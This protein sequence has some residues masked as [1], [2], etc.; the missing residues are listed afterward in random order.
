MTISIPPQLR[1]DAFRFVKIIAGDK[2]PME[3]HWTTT[4]NY[5]YSNAALLTHIL[6]DNP[7]GVLCGKDT[8][9]LV[10]DFDDEKAFPIMDKLKKTFTVKT[11]K[12]FHKY[13]KCPEFFNTTNITEKRNI[14]G[15]DTEVTLVDFRHTGSQV[16][17]PGSMHPSGSKYEIVDDSEIAD[18]T[19]QE[20]L[21]AFTDFHQLN[22]K[23]EDWIAR[24]TLEMEKEIQNVTSSESNIKLDIM[25]LID[26]SKFKKIANGELRGPHPTHGSSGGANFHIDPIKNLW[27]CFRCQS[28][29]SALSLVAIIEGKMQCADSVKGKLNGDLFK[30]VLQ[31]AQEK[32]GAKVDNL[33]PVFMLEFE[34][35]DKN[36]YRVSLKNSDS[37]ILMQ[38]VSKDFY[39]SSYQAARFFNALKRSLDGA[40]DLK[41][42]QRPSFD[43]VA[44]L[45]A[46]T[47][48]LESSRKNYTGA[49][50]E[51]TTSM[52][53]TDFIGKV[54]KKSLSVSSAGKA[55][56]ASTTV[57][58][59]NS[60]IEDMDF[61]I[62]NRVDRLHPA[63][64]LLD[65]QTRSSPL[66]LKSDTD[67]TMI[68]KRPLIEDGKPLLLCD[69]IASNSDKTDPKKFR[70]VINAI[71]FNMGIDQ[72]VNV[73]NLVY[74]FGVVLTNNEKDEA[75]N[76]IPTQ[77]FYVVTSDREIFE[78]TPTLG[79]ETA[80]W[81]KTDKP[82]IDTDVF[83]RWEAITVFQ[84]LKNMEGRMNPQNVFSEVRDKFDTFINFP[85]DRW[86]DVLSLWTIGTYLFPMFLAYPYVFLFGSKDAGKT[87]TMQVARNMCF[88][89]ALSAS[90]TGA[91]L[92][93]SCEAYKRSLFIDEAILFRK[94]SLD[95]I[96]PKAEEVFS[97]INSGYK[98]GT[99]VERINKDKDFK[100][101]KFDVYSPKMFA[102]NEVMNEIMQSRFIEI[103][104]RPAL[105][106]DLQGDREV[107][108]HYYFWQRIRN[109]LYILALQHFKEIYKI[110]LTLEND[111]DMKN[112]NWELWKPLLAIAK[113]ISEDLFKKVLEFAIEQTKT[114]IGEETDNPD[115]IVIEAIIRLYT[116][117][118]Y[119]GTGHWGETFFY[120]HDVV[121]EC[122]Q[123]YEEKYSGTDT[124]YKNTSWLNSQW[125]GARI[126]K[127]AIPKITTRTNNR[128]KHMFTRDAVVTAAERF[129]ISQE[130]VE[131]I[132]LNVRS[133]LKEKKA[134]LDMKNVIQ[135]KI[136]VIEEESKEEKERRQQS[137]KDIQERMRDEN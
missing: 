20:V 114:R 119:L 14:N 74:Y 110:Y 48:R 134:E 133:A 136:P 103:T 46:I 94:Q 53:L 117:A 32:Y 85:D 18:I 92:F 39:M 47:A 79:L 124:Q 118:E 35:A 115:F 17:G 60:R 58:T 70:E 45:K 76:V 41:G 64:G 105:K 108:D 93:R 7:Y 120:P 83:C 13:F 87:K 97:L 88:N 71:E 75:G 130:V 57:T 98:Q 56:R 52:A 69:V 23:H 78:I 29:G 81:F 123:I 30:E 49:A 3:Q 116:G 101:E 107:S 22:Q 5:T 121:L 27:H 12:G 66:V 40:A 84:F 90:F 33:L 25:T 61:L 125:L 16:L 37:P 128:P 129:G 135:S 65:R 106:K 28:G 21:D 43:D 73:D 89:G 10:I 86:C 15:A 99:Y 59:V 42:V 77:K 1:N 100:N 38:K 8:G 44:C 95:R 131:Q 4:N 67:L 31:I 122:S 113:F 111:F 51:V 9:V 132:E 26:A 96:S 68:T 104:M 2:K 24:K 102:A 54:V 91:S 127:L 63:I 126:K 11:R 34:E 72:N 50:P 109:S 62:N 82:P 112:R 19:V 6:S 36:H 137:L 55:P 80:L